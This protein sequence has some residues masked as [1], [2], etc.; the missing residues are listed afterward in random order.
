MKTL[1]RVALTVVMNKDHPWTIKP[2]HVS[3]SFRKCGYIVPEYAIT[4]PDK[5]ISGPDLSL[6]GKEFYVTVTVSTSL[7]ILL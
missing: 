7:K 3:T 2:W 5:P 6:Q 1:S 4:L